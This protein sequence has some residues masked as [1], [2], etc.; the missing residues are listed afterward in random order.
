M[1]IRDRDSIGDVQAVKYYYYDDQDRIE[2]CKILVD[3]DTTRISW[4]YEKDG[5]KVTQERDGVVSSIR[6]KRKNGK[7]LTYRSSNYYSENFFN[8]KG[9]VVRN[10]SLHKED[11][12]KTKNKSI[13]KY[14]KNGLRKSE[15]TTQDVDGNSYIT[16][17]VYKYKYHK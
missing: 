13:F 8:K 10:E 6:Q 11:D 9:Q 7:M 16:R 17:K 5:T 15:K 1:C 3:Q 12:V 2:R 4:K 14:Q